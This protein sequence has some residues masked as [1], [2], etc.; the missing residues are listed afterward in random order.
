MPRPASTRPPADPL[1]EAAG[2]YAE[3]LAADAR[4][5]AAFEHAPIGLASVALDG[6]W[7]MVNDALCRLLGYPKTE[8]L[9]KDFQQ[10]THPEDLAADLAQAQRLLAGEIPSYSMEKRYRRKDGSFVWA[11][12]T[13]AAVRDA[14]GRTLEFIAIVEDITAAKQAEQELARARS[15]LDSA[16]TASE[17][18]TY[19]WDVVRDR[20]YA[21][22]NF[23]SIQPVELDADGAVSVG[24][25]FAHFHAEDRGRVEA[26]VQHS[27]QSGDPYEADYRYL[28]GD[29]ERWITARGRMRRDASGR[30]VGFFGTVMDVTKRKLAELDRERLTIALRKAKETAEQASQAKDHFLAVLSHELRTP[31]TPVLTAAQ[32]LENDAALRPEQQ[33]LVHTVR[34]N[35]ELE[36]R[37]IDDLL[38]LTRI[39]RNKVVLQLSAVSVHEKIKEVLG[40]CAG[41]ITRKSLTCETRL[42]AGPDTVRADGARLQQVIW[43]VVKNAV[44]FTPAGG[45]VL[46]ATAAE[47]PA[48]RIEIADTGIG[49]P[50]ETLPHVFEAFEQGSRAITREFGGLGLGLAISKGLIELHG[51]SISAAS[52][53]AGRGATFVLRIP[54]AS[55]TVAATSGGPRELDSRLACTVLLVEDHPDTRRGFTLLLRRLGCRVIATAAAQE[56]L[57]AARAEPFDLVISDLGLPDASGFELVRQLTQLRPTPAIAL[58]GYGTEDDRAR[59]EAAGFDAHLVKPVRFELLVETVHRVL[60]A[61]T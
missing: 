29:T 43:N 35:V 52:E 21:D 37:L 7:I 44:K 31:L 53:G 33:E 36:A 45:R 25:I 34:R 27:L 2:A 57:A 11:R 30:V 17:V 40:M 49:I 28:V 55:E 42:F 22:V 59:S 60:R 10:L 5:R 12:L 61:R 16:L 23:L 4:Y 20:V 3:A 1:K 19:E 39:A 14:T 24:R 15:R 13:G 38:D 58:S 51:G 54:L 32:L 9:Q 56:A 26:A 46:I 41:D 47:G 8:L 48:L 50:A 18:G 6:R